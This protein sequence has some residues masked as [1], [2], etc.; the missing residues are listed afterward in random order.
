MAITFDDIINARALGRAGDVAIGKATG[1]SFTAG[2]QAKHLFGAGSAA[3]TYSAGTTFAV[4]E[5]TDTGVFGLPD[6][7]PSRTR[8]LCGLDGGHNS[9]TTTA[10]QSTVLYLVDHLGNVGGL[11]AA[12]TSLQSITA[13]DLT[14]HTD[15]IGVCLSIVC[16]VGFTAT[17]ANLTINYLDENGDAA[18]VVVAV[19]SGALTA[20]QCWHPAPGSPFVTLPTRGITEIVSAQLSA[21]SASGT[22]GLVLSCPLATLTLIGLES[23][24]AVLGAQL[25]PSEIPDGTAF[26]TFVGPG[27]VTLSLYGTTVL[28]R[29]AE[30]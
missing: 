24:A 5:G 16:V 10:G 28:V 23:R 1:A 19:P 26:D 30:V 9:S 12:S 2:G 21:G 20:G 27:S 7:D 22:F 3:G 8:V 4:V 17:A 15:G 18:S 14:R 25:S 13:A 29:T 11:N 6:A